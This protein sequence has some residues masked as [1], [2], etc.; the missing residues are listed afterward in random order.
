MSVKKQ[1]FSTTWLLLCAA[2]GA[3]HAKTIDLPMTYDTMPSKT[4]K[5]IASQLSAVS[6]AFEI[7]PVTD[8]RHN[9]TTIGFNGDNLRAVQVS[10]WLQQSL[11][12]VFQYTVKDSTTARIQVQPVLKRLYTYHESMNILGVTSLTVDYSVKGQPLDSRQ[13]RGF[14]AKANMM[15]ADGEYVTTLNDSI[16]DLLPRLA[17]DLPKLCQ[18]AT[19]RL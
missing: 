15:G 17:A 7:L 5:T 6:C 13:Y 12:A 10:P 14:Y 19:Q 9:K 2:S 4:S 3:L 8:Q 11:Q 1:L 18:Q 16:H